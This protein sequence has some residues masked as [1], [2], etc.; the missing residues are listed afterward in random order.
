MVWFSE[1]ISSSHQTLDFWHQLFAATCLMWQNMWSHRF[2]KVVTILNSSH[3]PLSICLNLNSAFNRLWVGALQ[4]CDWFVTTGTQIDGQIGARPQTRSQEEYSGRMR[5]ITVVN[6]VIQESSQTQPKW[7]TIGQTT[8][9]PLN[10]CDDIMKHLTWDMVQ[11]HL[12]K[13]YNTLKLSI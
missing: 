11:K 9:A 7:T 12:F 13:I 2:L 1:N 8:A 10:I 6:G 4:M 3:A 5:L